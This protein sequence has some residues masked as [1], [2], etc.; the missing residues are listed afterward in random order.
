MMK[1]LTKG[2][3][4]KIDFRRLLESVSGGA[5]LGLA[6]AA[7]QIHHVK[8][9]DADVIFTVDGRRLSALDSHNKYGVRSKRGGG[10]GGGGGEEGECGLSRW[11][12][13]L[14]SHNKYLKGVEAEDEDMI[15]RQVK[16]QVP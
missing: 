10:G 3:E 11:L 6:F 5:G 8:F 1:A 14:N 12:T 16:R 4:R 13:T 9:P 15:R 7:G 2:G